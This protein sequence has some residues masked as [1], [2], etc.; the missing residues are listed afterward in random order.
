MARGGRIVA[1]SVLVLK[2]VDGFEAI[3]ASEVFGVIG[4][5]G[6]DAVGD[7]SGG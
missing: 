3:D 5:E 1:G 6:G 7:E 2:G 4:V